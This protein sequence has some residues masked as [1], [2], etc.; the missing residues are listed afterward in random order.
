MC[1]VVKGNVWFW[2]GRR[3]HS[4]LLSA[5]PPAEAFHPHSPHRCSP[6]S[7]PHPLCE[8]ALNAEEP[9]AAWLPH[10]GCSF[11][12]LLHSSFC[13]AL[14]SFFHPQLPVLSP[15]SF[16]VS[17]LS[18]FLLC[19]SSSLSISSSSPLPRCLPPSSAYL[20]HKT[21]HLLFSAHSPSLSLSLSLPRK[22]SIINIH[23]WLSLKT[24]PRF[25]PSSSAF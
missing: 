1:S 5:R 25:R 6:P 9:E 23:L 20:F 19:T 10:K 16:S 3:V 21:F 24:E 2:S 17:G 15:L 14:Q 22:A 18:H 7:L 8:G 11:L 12:C 13:F 4:A